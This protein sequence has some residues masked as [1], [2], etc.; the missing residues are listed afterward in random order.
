MS[1]RAEIFIVDDDDAAVRDAP[2]M[3]REA[4]GK[5]ASYQS[6]SSVLATLTKREREVLILAIS[7]HA[8]KEIAHRLH[9]SYRKEDI[10]RAHALKKTGASNI[11]ELARNICMG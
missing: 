2:T 10:H 8:S 6:V 1:G 3:L 11:L 4:A 5:A 9:I 7:G